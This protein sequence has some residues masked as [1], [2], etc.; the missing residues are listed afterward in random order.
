MLET[1]RSVPLEIAI[2]IDEVGAPRPI[3]PAFMAAAGETGAGLAIFPRDSDQV[4]RRFDERLATDGT[5]VP[6]FAGNLARLL[7]APPGNGY[8]DYSLGDK[9]SYLPLHEVLKQAQAD[10]SAMLKSALQDK[11]VLL[12]AVLPGV[13]RVVQPVSLAAWENDRLAPGVLIQAQALRT[14]LNGGLLKPVGLPIMV[15]LIVAAALFWLMPLRPVIAGGGLL[16]MFVGLFGAALLFQVNGSIFPFAAIASSLTISITG[17][18]GVE[19]YF[20]LVERRRLK[21][22]FSGYVSPAVMRE[23]VKGSLNPSTKGSRLE[24]CALFADIRGYTTIS[25]H[26]APEGVITFL[27]R[28]FEGVVRAIHDEGGAVITFMGDGIMAVFGAP[29]VL[30][31][32]CVA[33]LNASREI[34]RSVDRLN[35]SSEASAPPIKIGIGLHVGI[36]VM[37][38]VGASDRYEYSAIGDVI[39][40]ASRLEGL[41]KELGYPIVCSRAV[42]EKV[43]SPGN[44]NALGEKA[45]KGRSSIEVFGINA[46]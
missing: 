3:H 34:L 6:T 18:Q 25:E 11:V 31:N 24:V 7:G 13:D 28:Y 17:R 22:A 2:T 19:T 20:R 10:N 44:F 5:E 15:L 30:E 42:F 40:T 14:I 23:I 4:V 12:G 46:S 32:A 21:L 1:R 16:V 27:N 37:G 38:H 8:I 33:A 35:A 45:I 41:T 39:N 36:A 9:F 26:M 29:N 43:G